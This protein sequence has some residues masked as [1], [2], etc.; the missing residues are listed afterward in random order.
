MSF[1]Y[2]YDGFGFRFNTTYID[3][4]IPDEKQQKEYCKIWTEKYKKCFAGATPDDMGEWLIKSQK[5]IWEIYSSA[6]ILTEAECNLNNNC[7]V[8][9]Y[10]CLYYA[11]FH[12]MYSLLFIAPDIQLDILYRISHATLLNSFKDHYTGKNGMFDE[13]AIEQFEN[14]KYKREYY[15]Y[16]SP[17]N[18]VFPDADD[19]LKRT[20]KLILSLF[21]TM[22]LNSYIASENSKIYRL[23][24]LSDLIA[25]H[26]KYVKFFSNVDIVQL[27][28][29]Q[30][31]YEE[32][33]YGLM[34]QYSKLEENKNQLIA[35]RKSGN[36]SIDNK[37]ISEASRNAAQAKAKLDDTSMKL[38]RVE[39]ELTNVSLDEAA[40]NVFHEV[41][42]GERVIGITKI[43]LEI[44]HMFDEFHGYDH[45]E[46]AEPIGFNPWESNNI[47]Y[48]SIW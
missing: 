45:L 31:K 13:T 26:K 7:F 11:L 10:F 17:L 43:Q 25:F 6:T 30:K 23:N 27:Y 16:N 33:K 2:Y 20:K 36:T 35:A 12:A 32:E 41:N 18:L 3:A 15:S 38:E 4:C 34:A 8:A 39:K 21:Q 5:S 37:I 19:E 29:D 14:L 24:D 40:K 1:N 22:Y 47:V 48:N 28:E 9:F 46:D 44:D 42:H